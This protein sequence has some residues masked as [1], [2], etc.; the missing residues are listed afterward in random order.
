MYSAIYQPSMRGVAP[1]AG[2][3]SRESKA[4]PPPPLTVEVPAWVG[5]GGGGLGCS[6]PSRA[7]SLPVACGL[8]NHSPRTPSA[9]QTWTTTAPE[10][11]SGSV[12]LGMASQHC[13]RRLYLCTDAR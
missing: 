10:L 2:G 6:V 4:P 1:G 3:N 11:S 12:R 7:A 9:S 8:P 5:G 13:S